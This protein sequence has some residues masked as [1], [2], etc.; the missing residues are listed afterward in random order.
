[1]VSTVGRGS[2]ETL[3]Y[4]EGQEFILGARGPPPSVCLEGRRGVVTR[5]RGSLLT[6]PHLQ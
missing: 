6:P 1:M 4:T 2:S 5:S 3:F